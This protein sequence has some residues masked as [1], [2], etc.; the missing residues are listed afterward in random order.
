MEGTVLVRRGKTRLIV[1]V[2][3][4]QQGASVE[5]DDFNLEPID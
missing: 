5:V 2:T 3:F 4:L 1:S